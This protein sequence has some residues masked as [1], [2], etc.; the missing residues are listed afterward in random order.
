[1]RLQILGL[2]M[3]ACLTIQ[4]QIA[5]NGFDYSFE[6]NEDAVPGLIAEDDLSLDDQSALEASELENNNIQTTTEF[7]ET[8]FESV[9]GSISTTEIKNKTSTF[10]CPCEGPNAINIDAGNGTLLS[11]FIANGDMPASPLTTCLAIK[12]HLIVDAAA[13]NN[14]GFYW[15]NDSEVRMQP[16]SKI[17][18]GAGAYLAIYEKGASNRGVHGC[19][20]L[21]QGIELASS[22]PESSGGR[23]KLQATFVEDA[24]HA[25]TFGNFS[26]FE[27][28]HTKLRENHI[29]LYAPQGE[30]VTTVL[31][32]TRPFRCT[33]E[34]REDLLP[35][36]PGQAVATGTVSHAGIEFNG[37]RYFNIGNDDEGFNIANARYGIILHASGLGFYNSNIYGIITDPDDPNSGTG[38]FADNYSHITIQDSWMLNMRNGIVAENTFLYA[39]G[40]VL[41]EDFFGNRGNL[42]HGIQL[43]L[44]GNE[45]AHIKD[46]NS[47]FA[48]SSAIDVSITQDRNWLEIK[49]NTIELYPPGPGVFNQSA[50]QLGASSL[51]TTNNDLI[52]IKDN[53]INLYAA[54]G[55]INLVNIVDSEIEENTIKLLSAPQA[56][57][58]E[59]GIT[60]N[61]SHANFIKANEVSVIDPNANYGGI[62]VNNSVK[63]KICCNTVK[64]TYFG[65]M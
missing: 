41:G 64:D 13:M 20:A 33:I 36:Y 45:Q 25:V 47:I 60:L 12:G 16:G 3:M 52:H 21:W 38:I 4:G 57:S 58:P 24:V 2:F 49:E 35:P 32:P 34:A 48:Q 8:E 39:T 30:L 11:T 29:G 59:F 6:L 40:N 37:L 44:G 19:T 53:D 9:S 43:V 1:M 14:F 5:F 55:G 63:N 50:I 15:F 26:T 18:V 10:T 22:T 46:G 54:G 7:H 31:Q 28:N 51:M 56:T 65:V 17:T 23:L 62:Y 42:E 61:Q 27:M